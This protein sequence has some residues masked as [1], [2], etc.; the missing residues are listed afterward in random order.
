MTSTPTRLRLAL[1]AHDAKKTAVTE[2]A[3]RHA[4]ELARCD[5]V[6]AGAAGARGAPRRPTLSPTRLKSG[7]PGG[8]QQIGARNFFVDP[9]PT[10]P[11]D[12]DV[13][14]LT[15]V[16]PI[17]DTPLALSASAAD[18]MIEALGRRVLP[19]LAGA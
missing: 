4:G 9:P 5:L 11:H 2:W 14:A 8:D 3:Q 6:A 1:V 17:K 10:H 12:V 7:P 19:D 15:R 13:K 16:A 18:L